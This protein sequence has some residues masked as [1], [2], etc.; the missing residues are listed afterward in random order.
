MRIVAPI[1]VVDKFN[2]V[3]RSFLSEEIVT[4]E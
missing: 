1:E 3:A 2:N 4:F